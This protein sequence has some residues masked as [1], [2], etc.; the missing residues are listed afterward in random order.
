[1]GYLTAF[2]NSS[3]FKF[4]FKEYFPELLGET[5]ELRK[6]FFENVT[7]KP[8]TNESWYEKKVSLIT[9]HKKKG[10]PTSDIEREIDEQL[11][12]LYGL[13]QKD[14]ALINS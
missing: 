11:F 7:V 3:I 6:V 4:A 10:L 5:R 1:M 14:I 13:T 12:A 9:D 2:L 8:V